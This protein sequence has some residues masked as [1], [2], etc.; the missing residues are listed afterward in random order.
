MFILIYI[1]VH[2]IFVYIKTPFPSNVSMDPNIV[3]LYPNVIASETTVTK[4]AMTMTTMTIKT[5]TMTTTTMTTMMIT[6][7]TTT[8]MTIE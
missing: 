4:A 1:I 6:T 3:C 2:N 8:M 5:M 7:T